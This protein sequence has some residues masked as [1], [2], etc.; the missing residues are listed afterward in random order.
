LET[1]ALQWRNF[2]SFVDTGV[3]D[4]APLT[5]VI[6][7]NNSGKTSLH[8]PLL[9]LKQTLEASD[10]TLGL[11]TV[12]PFISAGGYADLIYRHEMDRRLGF[13]LRFQNTD[14]SQTTEKPSVPTSYPPGSVAMQFHADKRTAAV[15]L[16]RY[17]V[18]NVFGQL[19]FRRRR[20]PDGTYTLE[21][22][23]VGRGVL[24]NSAR[25]SMPNHFI[26]EGGTLFFEALTN[27]QLPITD[28]LTIPP[29]VFSYAASAAY[30][31]RRL[32]E[33]LNGISYIG[34][35]REKPQRRY[36]LSGETPTHV[37]VRGQDAP[38][39]LFR[40]QD[41]ELME[42]VCGWLDRFGVGRDLKFKAVDGSFSVAVRQRSGQPLVG[43]ADLGFGVSQVL[44]L[45]V[46]GFA[47]P[48][49]SLFIAEQ[50]EIH[51]NPNL[52]A[53][54]A[55][56]FVEVA[57]RGT[58][59]FIETHSE[60]LLLR[61]RTLIASGEIDAANVALYFVER[62]ATGIRSEVHRVE[63]QDDGHIDQDEWPTGFFQEAFNDSVALAASQRRRHAG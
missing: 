18:R 30:T 40:G 36:D 14:I 24:A 3:V 21:G 45:I 9:L 12:G 17:E 47:A 37:G 23:K 60:H 59:L 38:E 57:K 58:A 53:L 54:L 34:P 50:P 4:V 15:F 62:A 61:L 52:Q 49:D 2:R 8:A 43:L 10:T 42:Q 27:Q 25:T 44:P 41:T 32:E 20:R 35:L 31:E 26:F 28:G 63:V 46:Q 7:P 22:I 55:N 16:E 1:L 29:P 5:I 56:L 13:E 33:L 6:G 19:H 11:V 51:L 48:A 39:I